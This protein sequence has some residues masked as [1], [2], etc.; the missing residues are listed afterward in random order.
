VDF[1][2]YAF[3]TSAIYGGEWSASRLGRF[4][5]GERHPR[6]P[7]LGDRMAPESIWTLWR[8]EK[9]SVPAENRTPVVQSVSTSMNSHE[10]YWRML[11]VTHLVNS[12]PFM[13]PEGFYRVHKSPPIPEPRVTFRNMLISCAEE[14]LAP[15]PNPKP[16]LLIQYIRSYPPY[17]ESKKDSSVNESS[18][19]E[20]HVNYIDL[21]AYYILIDNC[22]TLW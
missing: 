7:W 18:D 6:T 13:E 8:R 5:P 15:R 3:L 14:L 1:Q 11:I 4:T 9:L 21:W 17:L 12:Q 20:L 19:V 2:L 22:N 10:D 16:R